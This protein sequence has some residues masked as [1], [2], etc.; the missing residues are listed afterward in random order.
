LG[1]ALLFDD[2][3]VLLVGDANSA[4]M[5]IIVDQNLLRRALQVLFAAPSPTLPTFT[6]DRFMKILASLDQ[7]VDVRVCVRPR[8][9]LEAAAG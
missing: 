3:A 4:A 8:A 2:L 1:A 5:R 7:Q 6:V 9:E